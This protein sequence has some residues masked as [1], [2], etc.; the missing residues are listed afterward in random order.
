MSQIGTGVD[1]NNYNEKGGAKEVDIKRYFMFL[2]SNE[3]TPNQVLV[4]LT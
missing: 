1:K 4:G 2:S 3:T